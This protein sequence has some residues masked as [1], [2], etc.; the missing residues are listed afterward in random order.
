MKSY[1]LYLE[2]KKIILLPDKDLRFYSYDNTYAVIDENKAHSGWAIDAWH[3]GDDKYSIN[4][5]RREGHTENTFG[6][7]PS[8]FKLQWNNRKRYEKTDMDNETIID[9]I[10]KLMDIL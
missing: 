9:I 2:L 5:F 6:D 3:K 8:V 7:L 1:R 10:K 4:L